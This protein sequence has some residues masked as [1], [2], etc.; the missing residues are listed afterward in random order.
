MYICVHVLYACIFWHEYVLYTLS[1]RHKLPF[2]RLAE[3]AVL[4]DITDV[5]SCTLLSCT[6][7]QVSAQLYMTQQ[8]PQW[9]WWARTASW[10]F[11]STYLCDILPPC[12]CPLL[13]RASVLVTVSQQGFPRA[14]IRRE[15]TSILSFPIVR[16]KLTHRVAFL[17]LLLRSL[18]WLWSSLLTIC[19]NLQH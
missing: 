13:P 16:W 4:F 3:S 5:I 12:F 9:R 6:A 19:R 17:S 11:V 10:T 2:K 8:L 1:P 7:W 15:H 14:P 18:Q